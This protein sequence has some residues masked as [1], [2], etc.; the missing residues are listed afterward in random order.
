MK[1]IFIYTCAFNKEKNANEIAQSRVIKLLNKLADSEVKF[2]YV[3]VFSAKGYFLLFVAGRFG[4][5]L[6]CPFSL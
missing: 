5:I 3:N 2:I 1:K 4:F 6:Q